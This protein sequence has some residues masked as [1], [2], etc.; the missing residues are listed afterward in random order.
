MGQ[1]GHSPLTEELLALGEDITT[2]LDEYNTQEDLELAQAVSSIL[3]HTDTADVEM[4]EVNV[5][6][7][8]EPEV[9]HSGYDVNL[10]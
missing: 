8:F 7:G 3:P 2:V 5:T 4:E 1:A 9:G 6:L 10:V